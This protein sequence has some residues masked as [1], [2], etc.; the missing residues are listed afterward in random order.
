MEKDYIMTETV[1]I[2]IKYDFYPDRPHHELS[3]EVEDIEI[4]VFRT[5]RDAQ[6]SI[7]EKYA[8]EQEAEGI[9]GEDQDKIEWVALLEKDAVWTND[10]GGEVLIRKMTVNN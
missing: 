1:Y 10:F 5:F 9:I 4:G 2:T 3:Q 8:K 6:R 7:E